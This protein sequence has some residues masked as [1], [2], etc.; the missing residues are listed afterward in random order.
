MTN[1]KL[2]TGRDLGQAICKHFG[3]DPRQVDRELRIKTGMDEVASINFTIML[4]TDD[5][6]G[7]AQ[8]AGDPGGEQ[9]PEL[10]PLGKSDSDILKRYGAGAQSE[11][12]SID[13]DPR[14]DEIVSLLKQLVQAVE[15]KDFLGRQ[16]ALPVCIATPER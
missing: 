4:S 16:T 5:L 15:R 14:L 9:G 12:L 6:A 2:M 1:T 10:I 8:C 7:I 11:Q 3:L 13:P